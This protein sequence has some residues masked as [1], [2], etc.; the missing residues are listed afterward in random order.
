MKLI[1]P[2]NPRHNW[3]C[4]LIVSCFLCRWQQA[5]VLYPVF[6]VHLQPIT[7]TAANSRSLLPFL[8]LF[9]FP[10][11]FFILFFHHWKKELFVFLKR[12]I[13]CYFSN[14][15]KC[16]S[17]HSWKQSVQSVSPIFW[18]LLWPME[19]KRKGCMLGLVR[20]FKGHFVVFWVFFF[21]CQE[22]HIL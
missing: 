17:R 4:F 15:P 10:F 12:C 22:E 5:S 16:F 13:H 19:C 11:P 14:V 9:S 1:A 21:L 8:F 18:S 2:Q 6:L 3:T 20:K 7:N